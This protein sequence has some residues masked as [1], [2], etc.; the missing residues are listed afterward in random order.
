MDAVPV[1][2]A[3]MLTSSVRFKL[4]RTCNVRIRCRSAGEND[5]RERGGAARTWDGCPEKVK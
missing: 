5:D 1:V 3:V 4:M 2:T